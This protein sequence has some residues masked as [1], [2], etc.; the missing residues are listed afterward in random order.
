MLLSGTPFPRGLVPRMPVRN[1]RPSGEP[2]LARTC[3]GLVVPPERHA[4]AVISRSTTLVPPILNGLPL[5]MARSSS[6][7][8]LT[9]GARSCAFDLA[10][11]RGLPA[12]SIQ[13]ATVAPYLMSTDFCTPLTTNCTCSPLLKGNCL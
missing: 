6:R 4:S 2:A 10:P 11:N 7:D 12:L 1:G 13:L 8:R 9:V 5:A 3:E